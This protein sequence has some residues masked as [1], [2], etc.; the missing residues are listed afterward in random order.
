M[1]KILTLLGNNYGGCLQAVALQKIMKQYDE[2]ETINYDEYL[3]SNKSIKEIIKD[4]VYYKR[5]KKFSKFKQQNLKLTKEKNHLVDD[6]KSKYIVGSDQ[7]WNPTT[8]SY[9]I[10]KKFFLSFVK[11]KKRKFSYAA[12]IGEENIDT[13]GKEKEIVK[14]LESFNK[15]SVRESSSA[16]ILNSKYNLNAI[17]VLDPTMVVEKKIWDSFI[18]K[19]YKE[20]NYIL[21]YTLGM[22][23]KCIKTIDIF[24]KKNSKKI[25]EIF[26]RKRFKNTKRVENNFGPQDFINA[27]A[28][29]DI[30][31]TNSFHGM[32][33][34]IIYHK[35]FYVITRDKM[36]SR[37][38]D[39]LKTINLTDR[40]IKEEEIDKL[41]SKN[42]NKINYID[43]DK[44]LNKEKEK[45]LKYI[46]EIINIK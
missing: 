27:I 32:V 36:N 18:E 19:K 37:I 26:Y 24:S 30:I 29:S 14:F 20:K 38:Y 43:V 10:R 8:L 13:D 6:L 28:N 11:D 15:I 44:I 31:I 40:I 39:L 4:I 5:N 21:V 42:Y 1:I 34:S 12:S 3:N 9:E 16:K 33:F 25:I 22:N 23:K 45:S 35:E 7:V 2:V 46:Q 41:L 17:S